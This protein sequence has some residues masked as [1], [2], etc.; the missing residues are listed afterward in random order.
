MFHVETTA[1]EGEH[2]Y[3]EPT[4]S[5]PHKATEKLVDN[6]ERSAGEFASYGSYFSSKK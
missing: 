2:T 1:W 3:E 5:D 6:Q 4:Q